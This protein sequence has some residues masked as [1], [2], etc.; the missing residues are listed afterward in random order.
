MPYLVDVASAPPEHIVPQAV[1]AAFAR[2][3]FGPS[4]RQLERLMPVFE[5]AD[6][7]TR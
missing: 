2:Q 6:I 1:A 7:E 5:H 4:M 3:T